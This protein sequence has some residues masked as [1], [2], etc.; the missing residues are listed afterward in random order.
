MPS[1]ILAN[2]SDLKHWAETTLEAQSIFPELIRR[3]VHATGKL[4]T[5]ASFPAG[6]AVLL[7]GWDGA[8]VCGEAS[9]FTPGTPDSHADVRQRGGRR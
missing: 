3:L 1:D 4:I 9:A 7:P 8:L 2:A 6:K 5:H